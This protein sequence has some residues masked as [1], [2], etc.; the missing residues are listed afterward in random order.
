MLPDTSCHTSHASSCSR[1][2]LVAINLGPPLT[3]S[4]N[5]MAESGARHRV[6][7]ATE[8]L[9]FWG[10]LVL[11]ARNRALANPHATEH[12][13][14]SRSPRRGTRRTLERR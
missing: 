5:A 14:P 3:S 10:H 9:G 1:S 8:P 6:R 11:P 4:R 7:K 2:R 12:A 13:M